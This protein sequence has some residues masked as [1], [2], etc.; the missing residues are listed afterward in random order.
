MGSKKTSK[1]SSNSSSGKSSEVDRLT[2]ELN[3]FR[4]SMDIEVVAD[5]VKLA[6]LNVKLWSAREAAA[7]SMADRA[8]ASKEQARWMRELA[9]IQRV[10]IADRIKALEDRAN[11]VEDLEQQLEALPHEIG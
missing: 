1:T 10:S 7:E 8:H 5:H 3:E 11:E 9:G 6:G 2:K 4:A